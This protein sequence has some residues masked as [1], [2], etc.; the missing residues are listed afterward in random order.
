M[1]EPDR[2]P[3][4]HGKWKRRG[5]ELAL[6]AAVAIITALLLIYASDRWLPANF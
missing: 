2:D 6:W 1:T 3:K 5:L 4:T